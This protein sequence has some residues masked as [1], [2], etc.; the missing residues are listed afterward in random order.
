MT[1]PFAKAPWKIQ[2]IS[3]SD[4]FPLKPTGDNKNI[5][6]NKWKAPS[7][8]VKLRGALGEGWHALTG[9]SSEYL[10]IGVIGRE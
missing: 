4:R 6:L 2:H 5:F 1:L 7:L 8:K 9:A 3:S 10:A